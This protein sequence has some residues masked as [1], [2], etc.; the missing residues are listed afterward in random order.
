MDDIEYEYYEAE[1][2]NYHDYSP[3]V[4]TTTKFVKVQR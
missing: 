1:E 4:S 3:P 2:E